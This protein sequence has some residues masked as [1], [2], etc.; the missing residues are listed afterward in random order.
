MGKDNPLVSVIIACFNGEDYI[1]QCIEALVKQT[2]QNI[3]I[4]VCDDASKDG[5]LALLQ[6]W[7][8]K[9]PRVVVLHNEANLFAAASRNKCFKAAKGDYF[10]IQDV[11]D[12]SMP[13][14]IE[15]LLAEIQSDDVDFVSSA[16]QCFEGTPNNKKEL[17]VCKKKY[18]TKK[19]FLR[20][21]SF[22]HPATLF[23]RKCIEKVNGYRV[24]SDTRR[25]QDYDM[26]MRL[27]AE[28]YKGKNLKEPL[29]LYRRDM[30]T[31]KRGQTFSSAVCGY[32]VR[33]YGFKKLQLSTPIAFVY[34][35]RPWVAF[36]YHK[37]T[38]LL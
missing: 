24:S 22:C 25:C 11:D 5:S 34:S 13:N 12:I 7:A 9:D 18:P 30:E 16:M 2:Y 4:V 38:N 14:R 26:F 35:L 6:K 8:E 28:G 20:G 33:K 3:E 29:Y 23:T 17:I 31:M 37:L 36:I 1:D 15:R 19:D 27:Y 10:C 32:K 21:I